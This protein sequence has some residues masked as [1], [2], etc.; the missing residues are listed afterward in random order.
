MEKLDKKEK[1]AKQSVSIGGASAVTR[2]LVGQ[3][4]AVWFRVPIKLFRPT[5]VDYMIIP[6]AINPRILKG[7]PWSWKTSSPM[8][9]ASAVRQHGWSFIPAFVVPP[10]LA[11]SI[12][13]VVL[14]TTY[15][16]SL[17]LL[18]PPS[19]ENVQRAIP[20]PPFE[21]TY[22]AGAIAGLAQALVS[23]P[24]DALTVRFEVNQM[25]EGRYQSMWHYCISTLKDVGF[26]P[27]FGGFLLSAA[28]ES[29]AMGAFFGTFE[30]IK[31]QGYY[32]FLRLFYGR[33][34]LSLYVNAKEGSQK[35]PYWLIAPTFLL[36]S[37]LAAS[38][39]HTS[40]HF[41]LSK[42]QEIHLARLE[43]SDYRNRYEQKFQ[44]RRAI[45]IYASE[46]WKTAKQC[47]SVAAKNGGWNRWLF[48]G[49]VS[50]AIRGAPAT[51]FGL[52]IFESFRSHF[53]GT[54]LGSDIFLE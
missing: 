28:K 49:I 17:Q 54:S 27:V 23:Q 34:H 52:I 2:S 31:N 21:T 15:I 41:P 44:Q 51:S 19:S 24:I 50:T 8:L 22:K 16:E 20:P 26:K 45:A 9:L 39:A 11:N 46:Y 1:D 12:I 33:Q 29:L 4:L 42:V 36:V 47:S 5:R 25:L 38:V 6:R 14:Y 30:F 40:M 10:L 48:K 53:A 3:F 35:Q 18:H 32:S 7:E 37:G 43:S 13:G